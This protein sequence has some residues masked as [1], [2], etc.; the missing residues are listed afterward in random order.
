[1]NKPQIISFGGKLCALLLLLSA[2]KNDY[3]TVFGP[4]PAVPVVPAAPVVPGAMTFAAFSGIVYNTR[5]V[6]LSGVVVTSG[7][8]STVTD[9][10]GYYQLSQVNIVD[11]RALLKFEKTGFLTVVRSVPLSDVVRLDVGMKYGL[12]EVFPAIAN[13]TLT[14]TTN[15]ETETMTVELPANGFVTESGLAYGGAVKVLAGYLD[16]DDEKF[17]IQMPGDLS[18]VRTDAT[19]AQLVSYGMVGV[20]LKDLSGNKLQLAPGK[21]ATLTFPVPDKFKNGTLPQT[22]PLWSFDDVTGLWVEEGDAALNGTGDAYVGQVSH[23]SWHN[24]DSPEQKATINVMVKDSKGYPLTFVPVD[25]DGQ[26]KYYT[27]KEGKMTCDVP[28]NT[29]LCIRIPSEA[30]GNYAYGDPSKEAKTTVTLGGGETKNVELTIPT[31]APHITGIITNTGTGSKVCSII[32]SYRHPEHGWL[33]TTPVITDTNGS[34]LIYG[35]I[36]ITG[37]SMLIATF[38]NGTSFTQEFEMTGADQRVDMSVNSDSNV[39]NGIINVWNDDADL[40]ATYAIP[41]P[42]VGSLWEAAVIDGSNFYVRIDTRADAAAESNG[43]T[44]DVVSFSLQGYDPAEKHFENATFQY[45][46]EGG[47]HLG[48]TLNGPADITFKDD[49]YTI[50]MTEVTGTLEDQMKGFNGPV[51]STIELNVKPAPKE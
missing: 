20:E 13:K 19:P 6:L 47:P 12:S 48:I 21:T 46:K 42:K 16:P 30:Y 1:M 29:S 33:K 4:G 37:T 24:L 14:L 38:A 28:S 23:F 5:G 51:K 15:T 18:A 45:V 11:N 3:G 49:I 22:L 34:F 27:D 26:R 40:K 10:N 39:G 32:I 8:Q 2:C 35:P 9:A 7:D 44:V 31:S 17:P 41:S 36:G 43:E 50:K 25:V